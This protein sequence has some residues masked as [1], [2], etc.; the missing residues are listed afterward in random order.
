MWRCWYSLLLEKSG[1][2]SGHIFLKRVA[3]KV[4]VRVMVKVSIRDKVRVRIKVRV[5]VRFVCDAC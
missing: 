1:D 3:I 2:S 4:R 5:R